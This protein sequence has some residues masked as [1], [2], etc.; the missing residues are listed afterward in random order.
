MGLEDSFKAAAKET[1]ANEAARLTSIHAAREARSAIEQAAQNTAARVQKKAMEL[2]IQ[3]LEQ[4]LNEKMQDQ[5]K[6][7][8]KDPNE[9]GPNGELACGRSGWTI[10][11]SPEGKMYWHHAGD[12]K[13]VWEE[14][15]EALEYRQ[16]TEMNG[17]SVHPSP[18]GQPYWHNEE[19]EAS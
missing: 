14:P 15:E 2:E 13:S 7:K 17:W 4:Q 9:S 8:E 12:E 18:D 10:H 16:G 6:V 11:A 3:K 1:A 5:E 19:T